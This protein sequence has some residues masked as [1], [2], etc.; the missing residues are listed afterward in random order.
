MRFP[1]NNDAVTIIRHPLID[2]LS[3]FCFNKFG[4]L[5]KYWIGGTEQP[6]LEPKIKEYNK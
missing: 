5:T 4:K 2:F 3:S 6:I 1:E